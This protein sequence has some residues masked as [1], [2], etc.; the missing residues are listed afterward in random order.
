MVVAIVSVVVVAPPDG[1]TVE[2][3]K[4]HV[5]P[6]GRPEHAN[7]TADENPFCGVMVRVVVPLDPA[8]TVNDAGEAVMPKS[9]GG[10]LMV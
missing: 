6:V 4:L 1:V 5:A 9:A 2:G 8:V 10:R 7:D 3:E